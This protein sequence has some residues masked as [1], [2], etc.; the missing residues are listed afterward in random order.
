MIAASFF[1]SLTPGGN[2]VLVVSATFATMAAILGFTRPGYP[3]FAVIRFTR[4]TLATVYACLYWLDLLN[5]LHPLNR[6]GISQIFA[7]FAWVLVWIVPTLV[8]PKRE[9]KIED[10]VVAAVAAAMATPEEAA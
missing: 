9:E 8:V 1:T 2:W 5:V 10:R 3:G 4:S 6:V 7:P